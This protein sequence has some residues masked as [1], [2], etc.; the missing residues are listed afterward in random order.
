VSKLIGDE[1]ADPE[2]LKILQQRV[3]EH[4]GTRWVAYQNHEIGHPELGHLQFLAVGP[5]CTF[6]EAP[7]PRLPDTRTKINWRYYFVGWVNLETG[8]IEENKP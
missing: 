2:I 7:Q 3:A 4:P 8:A 1:K 5:D 6:T